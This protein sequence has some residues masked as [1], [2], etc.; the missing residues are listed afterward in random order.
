MRDNQPKHRQARRQQRKLE[1]RRASRQGMSA[2]LIICEGQETEPNYIEGLCESHRV[3]RAAVDLRRGDRATDP[4]SLVRKAR[5][6]FE[7]DPTFDRVFVVCDGDGNVDDARKLAAQRLRSK[8]RSPLTVELIVSRP[9]IEFWLL[10]H[11]EYSSRPYRS[12]AE[13]I[14]V[15]RGHLPIYDKSDRGRAWSSAGDREHESTNARATRG[16]KRIARFRLRGPGRG[17]AGDAELRK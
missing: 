9:S 8:D 17:T 12:A 4:V 16:G 6:I 13:A 15:L 14:E 11:F 3:N 7:R 5:Q 1:R 10:L 2:I